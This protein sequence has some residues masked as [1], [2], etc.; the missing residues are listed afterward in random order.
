M[1]KLTPIFIATALVVSSGLAFAQSQ[2]DTEPHG[3]AHDM[4]GMEMS[5]EDTPSTLAYIA[6][7]DSMHS[8]MMIEFTGDADVDFMRAMIPHHQGAIDMA[9]VVLEY[10]KDPAVRQLAQEVIAAQQDEIAM[11]TDWLASREE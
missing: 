11:M 3:P 2:S 7:N 9:N 6:A 5:S 8:D 1:N 4:G 10:G